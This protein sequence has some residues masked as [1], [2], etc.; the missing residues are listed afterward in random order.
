MVWKGIIA[1]VKYFQVVAIIE[2]NQSIRIKDVP[3]I[4]IDSL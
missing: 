3:A 2:M 4:W 1:K